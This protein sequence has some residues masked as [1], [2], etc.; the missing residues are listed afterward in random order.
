MTPAAA[1]SLRTLV[2]GLVDYAGLFPPAGLSMAQAVEAYRGH[3]E[4]PDAWMLGRFVVPVSRL[5]ELATSRDPG[6]AVRR[7]AWR[8]AAVG[9]ADPVA[10]ASAIRAFNL[11][12]AAAFTVDVVEVKTATPESVRDAATAFAGVARLY[13]EVPVAGDPQALVD[14]VHASGARAKVRTGG[15]TTDAFP[16]AAQLARFIL[17]CAERGMAWKATAG[18]HHPLRCE[19]R[20]TYADDA[21]QG[22]MFGFL[23]VFGAAAFAYAGMMEADLVCLLEERDPRAFTFLDSALRWR[24][25]ELSVSQIARTR[26]TFASSF[27]SCSFREPVDELHELGFL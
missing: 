16:T 14:A 26:D 11:A 6:V 18:L 5:Q 27:G 20:L 3:R 25:H 17:R 4:A 22:P 21:P 7:D 13:A 2:A 19:R 10:D 12:Y 15:V 1:A 23:N 8:L 24:G 9:G